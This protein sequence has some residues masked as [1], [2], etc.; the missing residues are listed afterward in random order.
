[1]ANVVD[2]LPLHERAMPFLAHL[3]ELRRRIIL[4][5][6]GIIIGFLLCWSFADRLFGLMQQPIIQTLRHHG[7]GGGL[8]Y[9][10][11]TEP[12][13]LYLMVAL[14]LGLFAASPFVFYQ[15][16]LFIAPGLYRTEKRYVLPFLI[17]TVGLFLAGGLFGYKTVYPASLDFLIGYGERFQP[18]ITIGE[19]TKLFA[20]II[21]GL[22]LMFEMP[23][24][25]FFLAVMRVITAKWM[26]RNL[27]YSVLVIFI[28]AAVITPTADILNMCLFAAPMIGLYGISIGVAWLAGVRRERARVS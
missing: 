20:T 14:V 13:N 16:W 24:L 15:I 3:E 2:S 28:A 23:I 18:M 21:I 10:N 17:S 22:G 5:I 8:V 4:C 1:M 27:R 9:L 19:Y 26:W 7:I 12:F 25:V 11:P 6:L